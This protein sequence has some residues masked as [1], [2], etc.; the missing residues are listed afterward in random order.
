MEETFDG[1][2]PAFIAAFISQ[3]N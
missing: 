2:L 3:K 1:S